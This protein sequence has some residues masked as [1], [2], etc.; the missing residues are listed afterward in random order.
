MI[1]HNLT[2]TILLATSVAIIV[3]GPF[4][5]AVQELAKPPKT[6]ITI[7]KVLVVRKKGA[8]VEQGRLLSELAGGLSL[9]S[10]CQGG[11]LNLRT[12]LKPDP[13]VLILRLSARIHS[14]I[15][16]QADDPQS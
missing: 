12:A 11:A 9:P 13:R 16:G 15:T 14:R 6:Y 4:G 2:L 10:G 8:H 7:H 3:V 5:S 1:M